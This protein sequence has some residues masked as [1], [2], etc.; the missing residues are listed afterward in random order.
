MWLHPPGEMFTITVVL[1]LEDRLKLLM[2]SLLCLIIC[3]QSE[4]TV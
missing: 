1:M 4:F 3:N 2:L